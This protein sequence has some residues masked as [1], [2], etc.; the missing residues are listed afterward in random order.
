MHKPVFFW[1]DKRLKKVN[2]LDLMFIYTIGNY[3]R[4][5]L[6]DLSHIMVRSTLSAVLSEMPHGIFFKTHRAYAVSVYF[7]DQVERDHVVV[8]PEIIPI[9]KQ[10]YKPL[11]SQLAII[12]GLKKNRKS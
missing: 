3:T 1:E 2:P 8:G 7:I 10:Y 12:A 6:H 11:L 4:L 5:F 9:A